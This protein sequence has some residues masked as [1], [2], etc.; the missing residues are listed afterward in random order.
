[1][2]DHTEFG[3]DRDKGRHRCYCSVPSVRMANGKAW[4]PSAYGKTKREAREKLEAKIIA[5]EKSLQVPESKDILKNAIRSYNLRTAVDKGNTASTI[6]YLNRV[7]R[8]QIEPYELA[9]MNVQEVEHEDVLNYIMEL[10]EDGVSK[11]MQ[12]KAYNVLTG[13]FAD[14]YRKSPALNPAYGIKFASGVKKVEISQIMNDE[15]IERY[16]E[17]CEKA[18]EEYL[19]DGSKNPAYEPN[20]DLLEVLILTYMR[21][22]EALA[23]TYEDWLP[24]DSSFI[25]YKTISRDI[26]G[27]TIVEKHTKTSAS[28]RTLKCSDL[29]VSIISAR[30]AQADIIEEEW[31][32]ASYIWHGENDLYKPLSRTALKL[33]HR[34]ILDSAG[35]EKHIRVHDLR[36]TGISY[37]LRHG[38]PLAE[39]SKRAGHSRQSITADIY[40]HVLDETLSKQSERES[41]I[42]G[43]LITLF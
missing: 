23:L 41:E 11:A 33:L 4:R 28:R 18:L 35:I 9:N 1:M 36:H 27:K 5:K 24:N 12:K 31:K 8:K 7:L 39:V 3:F 13:F 30:Q 16:F 15:E 40:S 10:N 20:A 37:F 38:S 6:E 19:P 42:A 22:G 2:L 14:Y 29:I 26:D 25:I 34:R 43:K 17:A 21:S 32:P